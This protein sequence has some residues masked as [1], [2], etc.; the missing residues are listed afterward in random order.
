MKKLKIESI[1]LSIGFYTLVPLSV[2]KISLEK[3][4]VEIKWR[5]AKN[6]NFLIF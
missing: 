4:A 5:K 1:A 2:K 3:T 6:N